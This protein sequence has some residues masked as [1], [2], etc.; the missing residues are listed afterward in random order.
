[1]NLKLLRHNGQGESAAADPP[2]A[3]VFI[4]LGALAIRALLNT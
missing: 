1:M 2:M 4:L 3:M